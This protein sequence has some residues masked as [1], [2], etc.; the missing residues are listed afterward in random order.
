MMRAAL[1]A[2]LMAATAMAQAQTVLTGVVRDF[3]ELR[4]KQATGGHPDFNPTWNPKGWEGWGCFDNMA[5]GKGA[6]QAAL[7]SVPENPDNLAGFIP[8]DRD[9]YGP[10]LKPGFDAPPNCFRSRFGEW[11]TTRSPDINRAFFLDLPFVKEGSV[12]KYDNPDFFPLDDDKRATLRPQVPSVTTTFGHRQTGTSEGID[13]AKHNYGFTFEFHAKF[14]VHKGTGQK[15]AFRGD[16][17]VWVFIDGRLVIDLGGLHAAE[18]AEVDIDTL[19]LAE[20]KAAFLDFYFAERRVE[21][22]RLTITTSLDLKG[23]DKPVDPAAVKAIEGWLYDRDGDGIADRAEVAFDKQP[24]RTPSAI[25]LHLAGEAERG[26]WDITGSGP[27]KIEILSKR[28]F[29][30]KAVTGWD[31]TASANL[32]HTLKEAAAGLSDG[33]F[34]LHDRIGPVIDRAWKLIQDTSVNE[35]PK[36]LIQIRFSEPVAVGAP[37]VL[38]FQDAEGKERRVDL[39]AVA[40]DSAAGGL[41]ISWTFTI[42]PGSP[43]MPGDGWKTAIYGIDQVKDGKG[44]PAHP[45]NPWRPVESKLP[46]MVIGDLRAEKGGTN[47][48]PLRPEE[49]KDPFVLLTSKDAVGVKKDYVALR[50][51]KA[52][53]WIRRNT[54]ETGN[55]GLVV[56]DFELS[57]PARLKLAVF[58]NLGQFVNRTAVEITREDMQ[59]GKL[60]RDPVTR[61]YILRLAWFPE[62][63]DGRLIST[64]AYIVRGAFTYGGDPRDQ[65]ERGT[66]SKVARFGFVR[67]GGLRGPG[68]P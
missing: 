57:H 43:D 67:G 34:P 22:S 65:V 63:H 44:N 13:M 38:K 45:A 16:D 2:G 68:R 21:A 41:S 11:Y 26:N 17:D 40:P 23:S 58:D 59:S 62:S 49:V 60:A 54:P 19:G 29:F 32:G 39:I 50:G 35:V 31:E 14:T 37:A 46:S 3:E 30:S 64:G 36:A 47:G 28:D 66:R 7:A 10:A 25:E 4:H 48:D 20:G 53:D 42:A 5:A 61:A 51:D 12:W 55:P 27:A 18:Y 1:A 9:G 52:P 8:A 15:F 24:D 56:F 6:V 33:T